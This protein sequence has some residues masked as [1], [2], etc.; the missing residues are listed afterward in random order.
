M[1]PPAEHCPKCTLY[2]LN[3]FV[4][5]SIPPVTELLIIGEAPGQDEVAQKKPFVG[6]AGQLLRNTLRIPST[7]HPGEVGYINTVQC[8]PPKNRNPAPAEIAHCQPYTL[9]VIKSCYDN[10]PTLPVIC[11]GAIAGQTFLQDVG[12]KGITKMRGY[13]YPF[14]NWPTRKALLTV[15]PSYVLRSRFFNPLIEQV[16]E[17]DILKG[18]RPPKRAIT[19]YHYNLEPG[20]WDTL[21]KILKI[22]PAIAVDIETSGLDPRTDTILGISFAWEKG[23][24]CAVDFS[25]FQA[26]GGLRLSQT[27]GGDSFFLIKDLLE[28]PNIIKVFQNG[29]FD[30]GFLEENGIDIKNYNFDTRYAHAITVP[31][32]GEILQ[33]NSLRFMTSIYTDLPFYKQEFQD[34]YKNPGS[35]SRETLLALACYDT[36]ATFR[37]YE[38]LKTELNTLKLNEYYN[39][40]LMPIIPTLQYMHLQGVRINTEQLDKIAEE[41]KPD[42]LRIDAKYPFNFASGKQLGDWLTEQ[43]FKLMKTPKGIWQTT[44]ESIQRGA[45]KKRADHQEIIEDVLK[46]KDLFKLTTTYIKGLQKHIYGNRIHTSFDPVGT[47]TGRLSSSKPNLQ[48]IPNRVRNVFVPDPLHTWVKVDYKS[49]EL[50]VAALVF[51]EHELLKDLDN[52]IDIHDKLQAEIFNSDYAP[53]CKMQRRTAKA[54]VFGILYG[55]SARTL[56]IDFGIPIATASNWQYK[57]I[58]MYP[59]LRHTQNI[60]VEQANQKGYMRSVFGNIRHAMKTTKLYNFPIQAGAAGVLNKAMGKIAEHLDI[61]QPLLTVHDEINFQVP[62]IQLHSQISLIC[63]CM[64]LPIKELQ[65]YQFPVEIEVGPNWKDVEEY[66][67]EFKDT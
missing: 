14:K 44:P 42:L 8:R 47:S 32:G 48:N 2:H 12:R 17:R 9:S 33:A 43:G 58:D 56:A 34:V 16:F 10:N 35:V 20:E 51:K 37:I 23:K 45:N 3:T 52:G 61:L 66:T 65:D 59:M 26:G 54:V 53:T 4:P 6:Q 21:Y 22:Q 38:Q 46:Y 40:T 50:R 11:V 7:I 1:H 31:D 5:P 18:I 19:D 62:T 15:H 24:A 36:D 63:E 25:S 60:L 30:I 27:R 41:A 39:E 13:F 57:V 64:Q 28:D 49:I 55:R 67:H 29:L